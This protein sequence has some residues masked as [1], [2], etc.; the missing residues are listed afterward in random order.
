MLVALN[1]EE[2]KNVLEEPQKSEIK[3]YTDKYNWEGVTTNQKKMIVKNLRKITN[4][5]T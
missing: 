1:R 2:I 5:L 4:N 3:P